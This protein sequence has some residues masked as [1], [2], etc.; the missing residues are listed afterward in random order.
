MAGGVAEGRRPAVIPSRPSQLGDHPRACPAGLAGSI[1]PS[2]FA[3]QDP[4]AFSLPTASPSLRRRPWG[5]LGPP[6]QWMIKSR[7][8][9]SRPVGGPVGLLPPR[10]GMEQ[11]LRPSRFAN[12]QP[13]GAL[14]S[15]TCPVLFQDRAQFAEEKQV[16]RRPSPPRPEASVRSPAVCLGHRGAPISRMGPA[17]SGWNGAGRC[18]CPEASMPAEPKAA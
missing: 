2:R 5:Q 17:S 11:A 1:S 3:R 16:D 9:P 13:A 15:P 14:R 10:C 12:V 8:R 18:A 6:P 7:G 4:G